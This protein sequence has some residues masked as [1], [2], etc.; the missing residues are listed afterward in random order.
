MLD[1]NPLLSILV[2]LLIINGIYNLAKFVSKSKYLIFLENRAIGGRLI[3]FLLITNFLSILLYNFFL[4][5]GI[6]EFYLKILAI[7]MI[8]G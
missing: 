4:F 6:N 8:L 3:S 5:F 7:L 1:I 2:S